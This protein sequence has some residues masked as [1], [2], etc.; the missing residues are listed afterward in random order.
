MYQTIG[1]WQR[2]FDGYVVYVSKM[3]NDCGEIGWMM[4]IH[5]GV[6]YIA[7][8]DISG[9]YLLVAPRKYL[10]DTLIVALR[11]IEMCA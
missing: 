10:T 3:V 6:R 5:D 7:G 4:R 2:E 9:K 1:R 8:F 11:A